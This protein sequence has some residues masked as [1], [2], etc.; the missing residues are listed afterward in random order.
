MEEK[1]RL[2]EVRENGMH[3]NLD[4][5]GMVPHIKYIDHYF[6]SHFIL[7]NNFPQSAKFD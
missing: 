6:H 1:E 4:T 5:M 2:E 7:F 3:S